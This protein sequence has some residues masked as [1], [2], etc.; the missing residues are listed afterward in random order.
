MIR[1]MFGF[2]G[3]IGRLD[4]FLRWLLL[5]GATMLSAFTVALAATLSA[6]GGDAA[7]GIGWAFATFAYLAIVSAMLWS[8]AALAVRRGHDVG[9]PAPATLAAVLGLPILGLALPAGDTHVSA[10]AAAGVPIGVLLSL[11]PTLILAVVPGSR[12]PNPFGP[13]VREPAE[14]VAPDRRPFAG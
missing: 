14:D 10:S 5:V 13:P 6:G 4:Y 9:W 1:L 8:A 2:D 3:R 7:G 12:R 11:A